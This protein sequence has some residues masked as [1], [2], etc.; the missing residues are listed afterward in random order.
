MKF[1]IPPVAISMDGTKIAIFAIAIEYNDY[2]LIIV[3]LAQNTVTR[4]I[5]SSAL[6]AGFPDWLEDGQSSTTGSAT[7][8]WTANDQG[9]IISTI[10]TRRFPYL[11]TYYP[12]ILVN[13]HYID[14]ATGTVTPLVDLSGLP[15]PL[16][17]TD[18]RASYDRP[19]AGFISNAR[20]VFYYVHHTPDAEEMRIEA[21]ALP[22][23][24]DAALFV[25]V[26]VPHVLD[27]Y[28]LNLGVISEAGNVVIG[29][30]F[31]L[32]F[33]AYGCR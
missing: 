29:D 28:S 25:S 6:D 17:G 14:V 9:L 26:S 16:E 21:I 4:L 19:R 7:L 11:E 27:D 8:Q 32:C 10:R 3:D 5:P 23:Q 24:P 2:S 1:I 20:D 18:W 22:P 12:V 31:L 15:E 13:F 30:E 33:E